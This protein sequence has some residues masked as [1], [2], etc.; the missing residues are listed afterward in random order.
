MT[1]QEKLVEEI[2][3]DLADQ[4]LSNLEMLRIES[5][6]LQ[7][8]LDRIG[9]LVLDGVEYDPMR[10]DILEAMGDNPKLIRTHSPIVTY[11]SE[12]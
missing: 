1:K 2:T 11:N 7:F 6:M 9:K 8:V 10:C 12:Y 4:L 5:D 3:V